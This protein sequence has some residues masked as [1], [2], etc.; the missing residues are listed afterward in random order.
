MFVR[1][2]HGP[3]TEWVTHILRRVIN[4]LRDLVKANPTGPQTSNGNDGRL[5][6]GESWELGNPR[7]AKHNTDY[8]PAQT[9][10]LVRSVCA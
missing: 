5:Q 9:S 4:P 1:V 2:A 3:H 6:T 8:S 7:R 10:A